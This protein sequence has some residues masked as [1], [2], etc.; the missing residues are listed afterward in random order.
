MET[1]TTPSAKRPDVSLLERATKA[2]E[3]AST[4]FAIIQICR[5][6]AEFADDQPDYNLGRDVPA[7][8]SV[9]L[10]HVNDL[11]LDMTDVVERVLRMERA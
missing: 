11:V 1:N 10:K 9:A 4:A 2:N 6:A 3:S 7:N 5:A 8:I